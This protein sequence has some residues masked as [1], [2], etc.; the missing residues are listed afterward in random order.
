MREN[1]LLYSMPF[2]HDSGPAAAKRLWRSVRRRLGSIM[3]SALAVIAMLGM[4]SSA[5]AVLITF[6]FTASNFPPTF[7]G[8]PAL[9]DPI[10]G[11]ITYEAADV[12]APIDSLT[13]ISLTIGSHSFTVGE[14]GFI[15]NPN[16]ISTSSIIGG[17]INGVTGVTNFTND[18]S[19]QFDRAMPPAPGANFAYASA[20]TF[21]IWRSS[22][23]AYSLTGPTETTP[24]PEPGTL[25]LLL[26][27][28]LATVA[29]VWRRLLFA[30]VNGDNS[31]ALG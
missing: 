4:A 24:V 15:T 26:L 3:G 10:S 30:R 1:N 11:V 18:F 9:Q 20:D 12:G 7:S 31:A 14:L 19:V 25:S 27:G 17:S 13:S 22:T 5:H 21:G 6:E 2:T 16:S 28:L 29:L 8:I 23:V